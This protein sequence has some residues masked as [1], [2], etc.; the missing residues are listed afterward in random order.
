MGEAWG[1]LGSEAGAAGWLRRADAARGR[2]AMRGCAARAPTRH[3]G[4]PRPADLGRPTSAGPW[5]GTG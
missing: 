4:P 5:L 2:G 3:A 1:E